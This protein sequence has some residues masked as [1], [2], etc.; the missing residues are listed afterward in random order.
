MCESGVVLLCELGVLMLTLRSERGDGL[1][2]VN[3]FLPE[4]SARN[5]GYVRR[6]LFVGCWGGGEEMK[7]INLSGVG[8]V[9]MGIEA[10]LWLP[11]PPLPLPRLPH[12]LALPSRP[13]LRP[14]GVTVESWENMLKRDFICSGVPVPGVPGEGVPLA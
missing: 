6:R 3:T 9:G 5:D 13:R 8:G 14:R 10:R 11:R 7:E 2:G 1:A 4:Y 12:F